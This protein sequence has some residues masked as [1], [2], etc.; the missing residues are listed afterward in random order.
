[1]FYDLFGFNETNLSHVFKKKIGISPNK[2]VM[3]L[4][5]EKAK[6]IIASQMD[7]PLKDITAMVGYE[8]AFYF[9][10]VFKDNTGQSPMDYVKE[11]KG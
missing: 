1:M 8:D 9:S 10:R 2:Y 5:I 7:I 6:E 3:K 11:I 4:R